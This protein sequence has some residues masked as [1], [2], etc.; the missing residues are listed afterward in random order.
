MTALSLLLQHIALATT[1]LLA[2]ARKR[3]ETYDQTFPA[4]Y[5]LAKFTGIRFQG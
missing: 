3:A 1:V 5:K 4:D 2:S